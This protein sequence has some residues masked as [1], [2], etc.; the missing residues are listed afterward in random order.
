M[1]EQ[2]FLLKI[3][4]SFIVAGTWI[5][6]VTVISERLGTKIGGLIGNT[7]SNIVVSL[8]FI[9]WTQ[10]PEFAADAAA[11]VPLGMVSAAMF[12]F[13]FILTA[14]KYGNWAFLL[15]LLAWFLCSL[16]IGMAAYKDL[17][18]GAILYIVITAI[19][20]YIAEK[21]LHIVSIQ[22]KEHKAYSTKE[23]LMRAATAGSVVSGA[24]VVAAF[25]GPIWGGVFS[26]FP[27][28]M[29]STMYL[30]TKSQGVDFARATGKVMLFASLNILVYGIGINLTYPIYGLIWGTLI[31][32]VAAVV[33]VFL[34]YP[35][36]KRIK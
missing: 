19:L 18:V 14:K 3:L 32:Y 24:V 22:N 33:F 29:L 11:V 23:L 5:T 7:P 31:S 6:I 4:L 35:F 20:F 15:G 13:V 12:L 26:T 30:L 17:V 36:L 1:F 16:A 8:L 25:F 2:T 28:V 21:K 9:G 27:A 34:F 10:T